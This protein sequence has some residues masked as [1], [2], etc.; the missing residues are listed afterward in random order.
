[1]EN[2][3]KPR[4]CLAIGDGRAEADFELAARSQRGAYM[5]YICNE[6]ATK[7]K[8]KRHSALG[9]AL[10]LALHFVAQA[11]KDRVGILLPSRLVRGQNQQQRGSYPIARQAL[12]LTG[13]PIDT[14]L[15]REQ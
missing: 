9:V 4:A 10:V 2:L 11:V 3:L 15:M 13:P 5:E 14:I 1:M 7:R 12:I 6:R 8:A